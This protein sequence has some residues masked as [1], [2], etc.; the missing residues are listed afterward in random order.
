MHTT[1]APR[2]SADELMERRMQ[3]LDLVKSDQ[4][5]YTTDGI[6]RKLGLSYPIV[7]RDLNWLRSKGYYTR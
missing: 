6:A 1:T 4:V 2:P 5:T 3:V 7:H